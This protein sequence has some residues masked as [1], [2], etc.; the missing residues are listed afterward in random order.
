MMDVTSVFEI[1]LWKPDVLHAAPGR[2]TRKKKHFP[3][4]LLVPAE[5]YGVPLEQH[6]QLDE[7]LVGLKLQCVASVQVR[8][9][10]QVKLTVNLQ[11]R[12]RND[13]LERSGWPSRNTKW[14]CSNDLNSGLRNGIAIP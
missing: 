7:A 14:K 8:L 2:T 12:K 4:L 11:R 10:R 1:S 6:G 13:A 5:V 9:C 3:Y